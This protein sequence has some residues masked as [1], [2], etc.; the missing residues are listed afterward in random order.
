M[1]AARIQNVYVVAN[2][3]ARSGDFY[4]RA[5][6]LSQKFADGGRWIQL[7]DGKNNFAISSPEEAARQGPGA[8][9]VFETDDGEGCLSGILDLG[10]KHIATRD[11]GDHGRVLTFTDPDGNLFQVLSRPA[12]T[13]ILSAATEPASRTGKEEGRSK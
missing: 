6:G 11:M 7:G 13:T 9:V 2:D 1:S 4:A 3:V 8:T 5:L 10:G 12:A